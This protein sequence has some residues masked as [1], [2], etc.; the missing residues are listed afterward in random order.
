MCVSGLWD[1]AVSGTAD[2]QDAHFAGKEVQVAEMA[3]L[4]RR[5]VIADRNA[6][7]NSGAEGQ[8]VRCDAARDRTR[9]LRLP[10]D[11]GP[12]DPEERRYCLGSR[13][14]LGQHSDDSKFRRGV[15]GQELKQIVWH[16]L[17]GPIRVVQPLGC[18][19]SGGFCIKHNSRAC[20][21]IESSVL[22]TELEKP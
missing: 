9:Y 7:G 11:A 12:D 13:G 1:A 14:H 21:G 8:R 4:P 3:I 6:V 19:L 20:Q 10:G 16:Q 15:P 18:I 5:N 22:F 2:L 17:P